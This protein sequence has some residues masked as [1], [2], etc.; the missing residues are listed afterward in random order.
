MTHP[1]IVIAGTN[2][3]SGKTT[4]TAGLISALRSRGMT[5]QPFK[6]GPDYIDPGFHTLA[7][8]RPCRN[9]DTML[10]SRDGTLEL[11]D[12]NSSGADI[13]LVEGVMGLFDG[14]ARATNGEA[15]H[16]W[17][18]CSK[19]LCS[20]WSTAARW[21]GAPRRSSSVSRSS[22]GASRSPECF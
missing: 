12:R 5:V 21:R 17:R 9:L 22:T 18:R 11:F 13:S 7:A 3:G 2:S 15:P 1:R 14:A 10:L 19:P 16:T 8:G 6:T 20:L 4:F